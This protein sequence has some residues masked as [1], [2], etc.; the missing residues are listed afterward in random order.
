MKILGM[1]AR[2]MVACLCAGVLRAQ[3]TLPNAVPFPNPEIQ[4]LDRN[5]HPLAG[6]KLCSYS[7]GTNTPLATYTDST[8]ATPNTN[9]IVLDVNGRASVWVGPPL[10]KFVLRTG[11]DGTCT[12]GTVVWTQDNV[13]DTTLYFTNYVKT[14]GTSTLIT[15]TSPGTGAVTRTVSAKLADGLSITDF[16]AKCDSSTDDSAALALA[17]TAATNLKYALVIPNGTCVIGATMGVASPVQFAGG[18]LF[19]S[20][21][22][23]LTLNGAIMAGFGERIFSGSGTTLLGGPKTTSF[24]SPMWW[25]AKCDGVQDDTL[26]LQAAINTWDQI[27][28]PA[29][30]CNHSG[31]TAGQNTR[32]TGVHRDA[33]S[34]NYTPATGNAITLPNPANRFIVE[35]LTFTSS[36]ASTGWQIYAPCG[37]VTRAFLMDDFALQDTFNGALLCDNQ[38]GILKHG[39]LTLAA[40]TNA[41]SI[42]IQLGDPAGTLHG[43]SPKIDDVYFEAVETGIVTTSYRALL[44][45]VICDVIVNCMNILNQTTVIEPWSNAD[46]YDFI[47]GGA[48]GSALFLGPSYNTST[49]FHYV[50]PENQSRTVILPDALVGAGQIHFGDFV[51]TRSGWTLTRV[52]AYQLSAPQTFTTG[53][54]TQVVLDGIDIDDLS[55]FTANTFT[56]KNS[57]TYS[58]QA[59]ATMLNLPADKSFSVVIKRN[60]GAIASTTLM[61]GG[62][63]ASTPGYYVGTIVNMVAG[64]TVTLW[65]EQ[66]TGGN[67]N[68]INALAN[69]YLSI[70][71]IL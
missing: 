46:T 49:K 5:G 39:R 6:A 35:H 19:V 54:L 62:T 23:T 15:Y 28:I 21:G 61:A 10:Y 17:D 30:K 40:K 64:D 43:I 2:V 69:T 34:L 33:S 56:A 14:V 44:T 32:L 50:N 25:G 22:K 1:A 67:L 71:R 8:A 36:G 7:A 55:E 65:V 4:F 58:V 11:G 52:K 29:G 53:V 27:L 38:Q 3:P 57:G 66:D 41:G 12:T 47:V 51:F 26:Y 24:A 60:G 18:I 70:F 63:I 48:N 31:L 16:G 37:I 42:G 45:G 9:P 20:P 13:A 68:S 59:M